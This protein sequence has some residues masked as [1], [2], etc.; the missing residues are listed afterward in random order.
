VTYE[1]GQ[2]WE[3]GT[4]IRV[5]SIRE[6]LSKTRIL[7]GQFRWGGCICLQSVCIVG[8]FPLT[9][10]G[11]KD[12]KCYWLE[13]WQGEWEVYLLLTREKIGS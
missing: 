9:G 11:K 2:V 10:G 8:D 7:L 12:R 3:G 6:V 1:K 4:P 5:V 13:Y